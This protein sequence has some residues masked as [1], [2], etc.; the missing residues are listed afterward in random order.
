AMIQVRAPTV[1]V[2]IG[3]GGSGGALALA[4]RVLMLEHAIYSVA[5]PEAAA[6]ILWKNAARAAEAAAL[7]LPAG[8]A[9]H[10]GAVDAIVPEPPG[11]AHADHRAAAV[12]VREAIA[13]H[14]G[15]LRRRFPG[16]GR[17]GLDADALLAAR[18]ERY[19]HVGAPLLAPP[20]AGP[21]RGGR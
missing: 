11:G 13:V 9:P 1:A 15:D 16:P 14:L 2:I 19:R 6:A 5:S 17:G 10:L 18:H 4:D 21:A 12:A 7:R 20:A 3:E 8:E